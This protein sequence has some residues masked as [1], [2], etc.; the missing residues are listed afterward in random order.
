MTHTDYT[1][2]SVPK[3]LQKRKNKFILAY[4]CLT[5][6]SVAA[7]STGESNVLTVLMIAL[8]L[9]FIFQT[10]ILTDYLRKFGIDNNL[11]IYDYPKL[12]YT[13][14]PFFNKINR[15]ATVSRGIQLQLGPP[16]IEIFTYSTEPFW[17]TAEFQV[18]HIKLTRKLPN[19]II[20][21]RLN[22]YLLGSDLPGKYIDITDQYTLEGDFPTYFKVFAASDQTI[23]TLQL[24]S[25]ELM[26]TFIDNFQN[27]N[28]EF[29]N[30]SVFITTRTKYVTRNNFKQ[31][32]ES[33]IELS[34][35]LEKKAH[36]TL[37]VKKV[38]K[39]RI[40]KH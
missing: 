22:D 5:A 33:S 30:T 7:Y 37:R 6:L 12:K 35:H 28:I 27:C 18:V 34:Q 23:E 24:M 11:Q 31:L 15:I 38:Y 25:P 10:I 20:D 39:N 17:H 8:A 14:L 21:S 3:S 16:L 19:V 1:Y 40:S 4:I 32:V 13:E 9:V 29:I 26:V 36:K 2:N